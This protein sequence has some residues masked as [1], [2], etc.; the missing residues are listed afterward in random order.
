MTKLQPNEQLLTGSW[1]AQNGK[2]HGDAICERIK[3][4]LAHHL[5]KVADSPQW[6]AWETLYRDPDDGRYWERTYPQSELHGGGPPELRVLTTEEA[7][8][9]Y[10]SQAVKI[11][12][13]FRSSGSDSQK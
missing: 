11:K 6:G 10:G 2:V 9:K 8:Q 3:W 7:G 5:Q 4:L 13:L 12:H 1:I